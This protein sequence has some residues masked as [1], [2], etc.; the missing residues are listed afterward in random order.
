MAF[1][2]RARDRAVRIALLGGRCVALLVAIRVLDK[3]KVCFFILL[4]RCVC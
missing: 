2:D 3:M 1:T 4:T